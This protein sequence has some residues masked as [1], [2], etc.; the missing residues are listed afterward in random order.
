MKQYIFVLPFILLILAISFYYQFYACSLTIILLYFFI[1]FIFYYRSKNNYLF[2]NKYKS[3]Q[4]SIPSVIFTYWHSNMSPT[5]RKCINSWR[6][7]LPNYKIHVITKRNIT[8]Y[9]PFDVYSL[10]H[11]DQQQRISDFIRLY[12]LEKH[13][14]IW[15]DA[16]VY[17]QDSLDWVHGHQSK[18]DYECII[19]QLEKNGKPNV[20]SWFL[21]CVPGSKFIKDWKESFYE[22]NLYP[23]V[24]DYI[25]EK[26]KTTDL[27]CVED[28]HYL[29]IYVACQS[30]IQKNSYRLGRFDSMGPFSNNLIFLFPFLL[31]NSQKV[32]KYV[33][34]TRQFLDDSN[35]YQFL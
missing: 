4:S 35:L 18:Y 12:L 10:R 6:K 16:S 25:D 26:E 22:I 19:Y 34:H 32:I 13:G 23:T 24:Q 17:L 27:S 20:E 11:S 21:A 30:I 9:L 31:L 1:G 2:Y 33:S 29:T 28:T 5:V 8:S 3:K 15:M 14:G 7:H